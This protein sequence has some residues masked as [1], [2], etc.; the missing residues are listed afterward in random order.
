MGKN[1]AGRVSIGSLRGRSRRE[2]RIPLP[3]LCLGLAIF[4]YAA[5]FSYLTVTRYAAFEARALDLGNLHQTVWNTAHGRPFQMTNQ[6]GTVNRLSLHVEPI[7]LPIAALYWVHDGAE[8]LLILQ[9][10]VV[11]LGAWPLYA[12]A[13]YRLQQP[14]AALLLALVYLLNPT[15]QAANWLEFH[16]VTLAP[17]FLMAAFYFLV[18]KRNGWFVFFALLAASCK[19]E[20]GLLLFMMGFYALVMLRRPQLGL[21]T[22][23][24]ALGWSLFA[25]LGIQ[26][27]FADGNIHWGRYE[28]LGVSPLDKVIALVTQPQLVWQQLQQADALGYLWRLLWPVGFVALLAPEVLLLALP[29]LAINLL[30]DFPPMHEVFTLIYAAPILPFVLLAT[31]EG[32]GRVAGSSGQWAGDR[33]QWIGRGN[34][35]ILGC[36][37]VAQWQ[38]GYLPGGGNYR[39]YTVTAHDR[40]AAVIIAQILPEAKVAAQDK[41]DPHV[42]GRETVYIFPRVEDADTVFV[43]VTGPA[44]PQHPNDLYT[45]IQ[46][47]L[48][49]DFGV[50]A[51]EDGY[52]LLR[53]DEQNKQFPAAF[54]SAFKSPLPASFG[55]DNSAPPVVFADK[56]LLLAHEVV[57][58]E[59]G[60]TVTRLYWQLNGPIPTQDYRVY[61]A[62]A[63]RGGNVLHDTLFYPPVATLWYPTSMWQPEEIVLVQTLPWE[64]GV[65]QFTLL[66][67]MYQGEDGWHN[68][69]RLPISASAS[70]AQLRLENETSVRLAAYQ[71]TAVGWAEIDRHS[72]P[73]PAAKERFFDLHFGA[74]PDAFRLL[75][76]RHTAIPGAAGDAFTFALHWQVGD[77]PPN[78]DYALF[79]HL[80]NEQG[81]TAAQLDWQPHDQLGPRPMTGWL[82]KEELWD[83]QTLHLPEDL[84]PGNYRLILGVY[85]WQSGERLAMRGED[86]EAGDVVT[87]GQVSIK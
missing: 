5:G 81:E 69:Q 38:Q 25:V 74:Q 66:V 7:L 72:P 31:V 65:D 46:K 40:R 18:T 10:I 39:H 79:A 4:V 2:W 36:A 13:R 75:G 63:D 19:E 34:L 27:Y 80:R 59:H 57:L 55:T 67:G 22:M 28:Y 84:S 50:A 73:L 49:G 70:P 78:F 33:R 68:G 3:A 64:L 44:W 12:L 51:G 76:M 16:P 11:A 86:A 17:T 53:K 1:S 9:S 48:A 15:I 14:W 52:L 56:F 43:D 21:L 83:Q 45:D 30:A 61:V 32:V 47:L 77:T 23:G 87:I 29:S 71:R 37:V 26:H 6:P 8:T 20:I 85:N 58:D 41:L 82:P 62:Y 24:L 35:L 60:E 54:Y 42:A